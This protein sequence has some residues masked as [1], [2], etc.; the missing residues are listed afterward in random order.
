MTVIAEHVA[1]MTGATPGT[2]K[3]AVADRTRTAEPPE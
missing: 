3:A 1:T 2:G